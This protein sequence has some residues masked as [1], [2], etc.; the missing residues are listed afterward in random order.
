MG[1]STRTVYR[2]IAEPRVDFE[3]RGQVKREQAVSLRDQGLTYTQIAEA[4]G[5]TTGSVGRMLY[6]ARQIILK[7]A[8][9][10]AAADPKGGVS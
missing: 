8:K 3:A 9:K 5:T 10:A 7:E 6:N 4:M 1:V 2:V